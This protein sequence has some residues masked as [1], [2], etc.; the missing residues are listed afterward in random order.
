VADGLLK[1]GDRIVAI[2]GQPI[3]SGEDIIPQV[4]AL[5]EHGG[6]GMIEVARKG[7]QGED[8]LAL[9][10]APRK[11]PQGQWMIGIRPAAAPAPE[12]DSRQQY[13]LFAAVPAAIRETGRMTADSLGMM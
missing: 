8:R 10:I 1:P 11:S 5:G 2:D 3:R 12:Y 9:E 6:P 13:G 7:E 4:Q